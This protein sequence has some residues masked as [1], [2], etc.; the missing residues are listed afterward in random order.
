MYS[1]PFQRLAR[2]AF[3][4]KLNPNKKVRYFQHSKRLTHTH[5]HAPA[6]PQA[7]SLSH[8]HTCAA[9][10]IGHTQTQS[11]LK[12]ERQCARA[13]ERCSA[14]TSPSIAQYVIL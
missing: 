1:N 4:C 8:T 12:R 9:V 13:D 14:V 11:H 3:A 7:L 6:H 10:A 5:T 2:S